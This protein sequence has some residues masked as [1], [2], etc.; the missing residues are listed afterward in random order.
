MAL[1]A[2]PTVAPE[3]PYR[4]YVGLQNQRLQ[5][6]A[7]Q[8]AR[9]QRL[10]VRS[11]SAATTLTENDDVLKVDTT[12][13][14]VTVT[15]PDAALNRGKVFFVKKMVAANNV[16]LDPADTI[17]G[18]ASNTFATQYQTLMVVSDGTNWLIV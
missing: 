16:V 10:N 7:S 18:A 9:L 11:V 3:V 12:G 2:Y 8:L 17:D 6:L 1:A 4:D 5:L 13:G 15:L 14:S